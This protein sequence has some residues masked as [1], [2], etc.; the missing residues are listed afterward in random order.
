MIEETNIW[1]EN[2]NE[3]SELMK[4]LHSKGYKW[5]SGESALEWSPYAFSCY[6]DSGVEIEITPFPKTI[7]YAF[8]NHNNNMSFTDFMSKEGIEVNK[9]T[10]SDLEDGMIMKLRDGR[11]YMYLKKFNRGVRYEGFIPIADYNDDLTYN[12]LSSYSSGMCDIVAVYNPESLTTLDFAS[13]VSKYAN[14]IW[15]RPEEVV[16]TVSEIEKKLGITNLKIV[17]EGDE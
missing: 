11:F 13:E 15:K 17:K 14:L 5:A 1:C 4:F 3:F 12:G 6:K 7:R 2:H 9:F 10:K 16:M 8:V